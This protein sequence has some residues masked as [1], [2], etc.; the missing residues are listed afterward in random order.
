MTNPNEDLSNIADAGSMGP[1]AMT[2]PD[3]GNPG[4]LDEDHRDLA[5]DAGP[6]LPGRAADS[7]AAQGSPIG[8]PD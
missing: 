5:G 1:D 2:E 8:P 4:D 7:P 6:G 3:N